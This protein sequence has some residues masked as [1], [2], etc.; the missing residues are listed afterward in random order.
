MEVVDDKYRSTEGFID[1]AMTTSEWTVALP[2]NIGKKNE[3]TGDEQALLEASAKIKKKRKDNWFDDIN[4]VNSVRRFQPM[5][6]HKFAEQEKKVK[7]PCFEQPKLDGIRCT[8]NALGMWTRKGEPI[9]G[10][11]HIF[12]SVAHIFADYPNAVLD[13]E[14]YNHTYRDDFDTIT[15]CVRTSN[16][17]AEELV[18]SEAIIEY[19]VYDILMDREDMSLFED[20][21]GYFKHLKGLDK[22]ELVETTQCFDKDELDNRYGY[23]L[24]NGYEGQMVRNNTMYEEKR[25]YHLQKRKE[26]IDDEFTILDVLEGKGNRSGMAGKLLVIVKDDITCETGIRGNFE[27]FKKLFNNKQDYIGKSATVRFQNYTPEG[28]LRFPV[29]VNVAREDYE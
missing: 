20:R 14:L 13:G 17:T 7:Y 5:L 12:K 26:F 22:I 19:H 16:P 1:G 28:R 10:A 4:D 11:P 21:I 2:K 9:L 24:E 27:F 25:S 3:T 18:E 6:A 15:S 29:T 8:I 23:H